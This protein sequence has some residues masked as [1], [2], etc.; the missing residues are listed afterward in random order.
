MRELAEARANE[1][2][3]RQANQQM[4]EFLGM[5][6]HELK[7]PLTSIKGNTQLAVRQ[8]KNSLQSLEKILGLY[9][10]AEQQSRRLNR[11]VDDLLD[12]SR[13][14]AGYL[15]L[16]LAACDLSSI[17]LQ[18]VEAQRHA[19][20]NRTIT[21][22]DEDLQTASVNADAD[23]IAQVMMNYL[24]NA[25][26]YSDEDQPVQV[27]LQK[28]GGQVRVL[29][30]DHGPGLSAE[31]RAY[32]WER[33]RRIPDIEVHSSYF[34]SNEGLG[35]GLFISKTIIEQHSGQVG[36]DSTPGEGSAFWFTLPLTHEAASE[37]N[38]SDES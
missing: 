6:S 22:D 29:V 33:F 31:Q 38:S 35:L 25:L 27:S 26:K 9:E 37:A 20:P 32:I 19:W 14:R 5:I 2:A 34:H 10:G 4:E 28:Q 24:T 8:L 21:L 16:Q 17:V 36:V 13:V 3:L 23:R 11:L 1:L 7:T 18:S 12:V 30:R 15:D